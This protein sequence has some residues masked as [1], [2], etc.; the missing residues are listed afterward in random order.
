MN[1][2][3][4]KPLGPLSMENMGRAADMLLC[5]V[6]SPSLHV[7]FARL[8]GLDWSAG[9]REGPDQS[10]ACHV[11][12]SPWDRMGWVCGSTLSGG[13]KRLP[14]CQARKPGP[15]S[16][17]L[18]GMVGA[19][20]G[21][22]PAPGWGQEVVQPPPGSSTG[23]HISLRSCSVPAGRCQPGLCRWAG[24]AAPEGGECVAPLCSSTACHS[25]ATSSSWG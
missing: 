24:T 15:C 19:G 18:V 1:K 21:H 10:P 2:A 7:L 9:R 11:T 16:A 8:P 4:P 12:D 25:T 6:R 3:Q 22:S 14:G 17:L 13:W 20:P 5:K 23:S